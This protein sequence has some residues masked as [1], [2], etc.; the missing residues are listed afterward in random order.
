[1]EHCGLDDLD[2]YIAL[3]LIFLGAGNFVFSTLTLN[4][5][6][7]LFIPVSY[8]CKVG[9][10][11]KGV[12]ACGTSAEL[13]SNRITASTR[14]LVTVCYATVVFCTKFIS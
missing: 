6:C 4:F 5:V 13:S 8:I 14:P 3:F 12:S 2:V 9:Q 11:E 7:C 1:M 10:C